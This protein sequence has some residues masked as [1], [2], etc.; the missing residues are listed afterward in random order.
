MAF[1]GVRLGG[2]PALDGLCFD[3]FALRNPGGR[4]GVKI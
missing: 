3:L 1:G 4:E 2:F